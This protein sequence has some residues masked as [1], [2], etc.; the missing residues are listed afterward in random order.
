MTTAPKYV[1]R[2]EAARQMSV[3]P[4][5]IDRW[6]TKGLTAYKVGPKPKPKERDRRPVRIPTAALKDFMERIGA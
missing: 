2:S 5:T 6:I 4:S 3:H 1:S